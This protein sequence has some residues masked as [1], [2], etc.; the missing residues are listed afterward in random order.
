[1][2]SKRRTNDYS[3]DEGT[4]RHSRGESFRHR[5][6]KRRRSLSPRRSEGALGGDLYIPDYDKDGYAPGPRYGKPTEM[7]Y[8]P[9]PYHPV[10]P[11]GFNVPPP[12]LMPPGGPLMPM[13]WTGPPG[14][15]EP[16]KDPAEL[17]FL[18]TYKYFVDYLMYKNPNTRCDDEELH[19]KYSAYKEEF[20]FRQL[21]TFFETHKEEEWF[22][23]KYEPK[24]LKPRIDEANELKKKLFEKF[25]EE[26][27]EGKF[28]DIS[29]DTVEPVEGKIDESGSEQKNEQEEESNRLFIKSVPPTISRS[30]IVEMCERVEG[31]KYLALSEPNPQ[32]KFHRLG[33]IVFT[34]ETD[35]DE[36]FKQLNE[37]KIDDFI[38]YL[39]RHKSH[40][41]PVRN[42][43]APE[44]A[45]TPERLKKD[46][47]RVE[48]LI[49]KLD[50]DIGIVGVKEKIKDRLERLT[51]SVDDE[52]MRIKKS[53]DLHMEY[54]RRTHLFCYYCGSD[55][56]SME[57]F[58]RKCP[59]RHLRKSAATNETKAPSK[60]PKEKSNSAAQWIKTLDNKIDLKLHPQEFLEKIGTLGGK[61]V[62]TEIDNLIRD[63]TAEME[64]GVKFRCKLCGKLFKGQEFVRKHINLKHNDKLEEVRNDCAFF[65]NYVLDP[66]HLLPTTPPNPTAGL[67]V[68][69]NNPPVPPNPFPVI[70]NGP[71]PPFLGF[72]F[73][74]MGAAA[75]T[76]HDQIPRIGF[77][78]RGDMRDSRG[79][80]RSPGK[81]QPSSRS[82]LNDAN[83]SFDPRQV[84]SYVDLDA[85]AEGDIEIQY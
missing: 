45:T 30:K 61:K 19:R 26:L 67:L 6:F 71:P 77:D 5:R 12:Q 35:M 52:N 17:D 1:M 31:F 32:K 56:D 7:R 63:N 18:V 72:N 74:L 41:G 57:E 64:P 33:W 42:R 40:S 78:D 66:N 29:N 58:T 36:A 70:P 51:E 53:L 50:N 84:K 34:E 38:F 43:V 60:N 24:H 48:E 80:R 82:R 54:L 3:D 47:E 8:P 81:R 14:R 69:Q 21:R 85:P 68:P 28:D 55:S 59:G 9:P 79:G 10:M 20:G 4:P 39:A 62:E 25:V 44:T 16:P 83:M 37:Q 15:Q 76:P 73:P 46:L 65:N 49:S 27:D 75:G 23:E 22:L 2:N 11:M 13:D